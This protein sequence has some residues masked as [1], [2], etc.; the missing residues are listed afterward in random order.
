MDFGKA[1][2]LMKNGHKLSR[3]GWNGSNMFAFYQKG[4]PQGIKCNKQ[5][6]LA[7]GIE[8]GQLFKCQPY[9]QLRTVDGSF[10]MWVPSVSD[11]LADDWGVVV[12]GMVADL[13]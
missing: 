13:E 4:Y 11:V 9:L 1:L 7:V 2:R 8:E 10:A 6:A 5:T 3:E 12:D